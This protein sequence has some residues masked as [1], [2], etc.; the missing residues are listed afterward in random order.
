[1]KS[2][3]SELFRMKFQNFL[4]TRKEGDRAVW[5]DWAIYCTLGNFYNTVA[6]YI[7]PKSRIFRQF[8]KLSK[9]FILLVKSFLAHFFIDIWRLFFTGHPGTDKKRKGETHMIRN[10]EDYPDVRQTQ[11][12]ANWTEKGESW[13]QQQQ[14]E[15]DAADERETDILFRQRGLDLETSSRLDQSDGRKANASANQIWESRGSVE[16]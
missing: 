13:Q 6:T 15:G 3:G 4:R 7:L 14:Q 9:S 11:T 5:P 10:P 16:A 8:L 2:P 12:G 1:M